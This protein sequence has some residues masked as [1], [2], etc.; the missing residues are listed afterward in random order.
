[1][2]SN[3]THDTK[4]T[5]QRRQWGT[6]SHQFKKH[7]P[8]AKSVEFWNPKEYAPD[9]A[10]IQPTTQAVIEARFSNVTKL[11]CVS[12][13]TAPII[14]KHAMQASMALL[15]LDLQSMSLKYQIFRVNL[16]YAL[17][18]YV[19][20]DGEWCVWYKDS[21]LGVVVKRE[22]WS[23][24][25]AGNTLE[26]AIEDFRR[27]ATEIAEI[28]RHESTDELTEEARR[29]RDFVLRYLPKDE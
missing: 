2:L 11:N 9:V 19:I 24:M 16:R 8:G 6:P 17:G 3:I 15:D 29:M 25:G 21:I 27:E 18:P 28:M 14:A 20:I 4:P 13:H 1:M 10:L 12:K 5:T 22:P 26:T 7:S 23:L